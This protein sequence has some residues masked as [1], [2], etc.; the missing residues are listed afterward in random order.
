VTP[1]EAAAPRADEAVAGTPLAV[2]Y[3]A[4]ARLTAERAV[5]AGALDDL[6]GAPPEPDIVPIEV[7]APAA[8][9]ADEEAGVVPIE[10]LEEE[11]AEPPPADDT[12]VVPIESLLYQ[13]RA[14]LQRALALQPEIEALLAESNGDAE[15][16]SA[17]LRE[18]FDLVQLGTGAAR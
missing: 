14:A 16:V 3:T 8:A 10:W 5:P 12:D 11:A 18:V 7:L 9:R 13:G 6:F 17:L 15:K 4:L 2:A 1:E